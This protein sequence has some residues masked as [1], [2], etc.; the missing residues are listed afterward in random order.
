MGAPLRHAGRLLDREGTRQRL[1]LLVTDGRP[2][3]DGYDP[4]S[5]YAQHD[6]RMACVENERRGIATFAIST[7]EN[8]EADMQLMFPR[9]RF[10]ILPDI[11]LLPEVLP[12]LFL[13][14]TT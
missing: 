3:D 10:V 6:V 12:R 2:M 5:R 14:V 13:R 11:R 7:E 8:S 4:H 1:L 9:G